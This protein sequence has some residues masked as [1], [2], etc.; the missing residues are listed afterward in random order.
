MSKA[1]T[2]GIGKVIATVVAGIFLFFIVDVYLKS[3]YDDKDQKRYDRIVL[4]AEEKYR[5]TPPDYKSALEYYQKG[6][7][8]AF[9]NGL[10]DKKAI[11]GI[12]KCQAKLNSN[13]SKNKPQDVKVEV[14]PGA[15]KQSEPVS[16]ELN[17]NPPKSKFHNYTETANGLNI[18][19]IAVKGGSFTMGSK[20]GA[21][22]ERKTHT[23]NMPDFYIGKYEVTVREFK[24]FIDD[25]QYQTDADKGGYSYVWDGSLWSKK[26]GVNWQYDIAGNKRPK[27]EY[28]HPVIH[29]SWND[30][31][32]F[33]KW[34]SEQTGKTYRLPSESE[35]EFA[36]RGRKSKGYK[37]SGS[38]FPGNVAWFSDNAKRRTQSVGGKDPNKLGIYDM[39]GNVWEWC[40]D[41]YHDS[42]RDAPDDGSAWIAGDGS[43]RVMRGGGWYNRVSHCRVAN[44]FNYSSSARNGNIGFRLAHSSL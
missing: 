33:A 34:V 3:R 37:Y 11:D 9:E 8:I 24:A 44:R 21:S 10:S 6:K 26:K 16:D 12:K 43:D 17:S 20:D 25:T 2:D 22:D 39:S 5:A 32:A 14:N 19:M 30:A 28:N 4:R 36:A 31:V 27:S 18:E 7:E 40:Q 38:D 23:V 15:K 1:L 41:L 35:W 29:V 13:L 42:Y